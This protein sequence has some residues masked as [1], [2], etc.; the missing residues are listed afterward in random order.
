[1][2]TFKDSSASVASW[3][4][5]ILTCLCLALGK[6]PSFTLLHFHEF[7]K[8]ENHWYWYD[9]LTLFL[10]VNVTYNRGVLNR[11]FVSAAPVTSMLCQKYSCRTVV[12]VGGLFCALGLTTSYFAT[13]LIHLFFTFGVLTGLHLI[14]LPQFSL[15]QSIISCYV[16]HRSAV[17]MSYFTERL[18]WRVP[19]Q[20]SAVA[21]RRRQ[22]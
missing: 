18:K 15:N 11:Y 5:A 17:P 21:C 13:R 16:L 12:F 8:S 9:Q 7:R 1:M 22:V 2:E 19:L 4:P 3:I 6:S 14:F 10:C 20:V